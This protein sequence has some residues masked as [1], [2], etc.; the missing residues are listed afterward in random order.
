MKHWSA[1]EVER[2]LKANGWYEV[3]SKGGH[4]HFKHPEIPGKVTLSLHH[5]K[6]LSVNDI[7]SISKITGI[8]F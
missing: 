7:K 5:G 4:F 1:R 6:R 8:Q 3:G 2:I